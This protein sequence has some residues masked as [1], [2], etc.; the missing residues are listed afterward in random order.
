MQLIEALELLITP[1]NEE[2]K[3]VEFTWDLIDYERDYIW[4]QLTFLNPWD[5]SDSAQF[6]TLSVTFWGV[7]YFKSYQDKEV[8]FGTT[9]YWPLFRQ[10]DPNQKEAIET[11]DSFLSVFTIATILLIL[12]VITAG[13][14]LPTWMFINSLQIIAHMA[15]LKTLMPANAHYFLSKYLD[16]LR[17]Y[18]S[19]FIDHLDAKYHFKTYT[20][21]TGAYNTLLEACDYNPLFAQNMVLILIVLGIIVM[22][23]VVAAIKDLLCKLGK[24]VFC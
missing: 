19:G 1:D 23:L 3:K 15:L 4:L 7:D 21:N 16:W 14:L 20:L 8:L 5:I 10:I 6:D 2:A 24:C 17:W 12:P 11:M 13:S 18:D 22:I 9:L